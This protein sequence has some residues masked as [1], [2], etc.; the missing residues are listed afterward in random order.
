[1]SVFIKVLVVEDHRVVRAG[2]VAL[3]AQC[4]D[5]RVVGEAG[6]GREALRQLPQCQPDV[7]LMDLQMPVMDGVEAT[8]AIQRRWPHVA[9]LVLTTYDDDE[10]IW[11]GIQAG[12]RGYLLKDTPPSELFDG[13]RRVA[14]GHTLIPPDIAAK[15]A[16]HIQKA[17][18]ESDAP[19]A[20]TERERELLQLI[21]RGRTN[22]EIAAAIFISEN[23]VKTHLSNI[24]QKLAVHDRTEAVTKAL[25]Q[26][27]IQL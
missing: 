15:L 6:D 7:V 16:Q 10:L 14:A 12:A 1:M 8:Q 19:G 18:A 20:L 9:V 24:Y 27:L 11:R 3:L 17:S 21:A 4:A 25:K 26:G 22:K 13:I 2:L 23:T 5:L